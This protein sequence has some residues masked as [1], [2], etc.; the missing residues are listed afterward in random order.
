MKNIF[1]LLLVP[2][3]L[4]GCAS[5]YNMEVL[6]SPSGKLQRTH[7]VAIQTPSN[8]SFGG[9]SYSGSGKMTA[10][11]FKSGFSKYS[12]D[13]K[14]VS[15]GKTRSDYAGL[16][17]MYYVEPKILH[18]EERATEWSGKRD[19]IEIKVNVYDTSSM[20]NVSSVVFTG[21]SK[22]L[23]L[24]GDHPQE[25]LPKPIEDYLKTLY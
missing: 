19:K 10:G 17:K 12:S 16:K 25:L 24:G 15:D 13:V 3:V 1:A 22:W 23:T 14:S 20:N 7:S 4:T 8:G 2:V 11:A 9:Q 5:T 18:W 6:K 21:K